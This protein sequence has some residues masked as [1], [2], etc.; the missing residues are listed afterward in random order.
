MPYQ[1]ASRAALAAVLADL[2][3]STKVGTTP[4]PPRSAAASGAFGITRQAEDTRSQRPHLVA[5]VRAGATFRKG[6]PI[7]H[8]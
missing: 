7:E 8:E 4:W 2:G 1:A 6:V 5:L 3:R